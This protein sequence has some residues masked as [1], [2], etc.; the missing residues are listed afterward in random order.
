MNFWKTALGYVEA[1]PP[2]GF[3]SW[4]AWLTHFKVPEEEWGDG[5]SLV[6]P[7]G[8]LP[9]VGFLKVPEGKVVKNRVHLDLKVSGGRHIDQGLR[10][11]RILAMVDRLVAL[12]G[13]VL[14]RDEFEGH[15]DH[16]VLADPEGNELCLV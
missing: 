4:E 7:A 9:N 5:G 10:R 14:H 3:D 12:G 8:V 1:P 13:S 11:E 15:L 6:D 16:V 2:T